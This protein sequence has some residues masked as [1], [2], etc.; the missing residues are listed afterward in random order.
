VWYE[1]RRARLGDEFAEAIAAALGRISEA[2][3]AYPRWTGTPAASSPIRR[4]VV[5]RFP[6]VIAFE[7]QSERVFVLAI[8]H[9]KRRPLY[10]LARATE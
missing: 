5:Q 9:A 7:H 8:A 3:D 6:Y 2:P 1:D 4:A 10:W